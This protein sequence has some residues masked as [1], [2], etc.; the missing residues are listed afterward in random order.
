MPQIQQVRRNVDRT[1]RID[2]RRYAEQI[3]LLV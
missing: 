1:D 2:I 3:A